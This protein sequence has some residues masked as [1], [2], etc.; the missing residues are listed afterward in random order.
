[1]ETKWEVQLI[2]IQYEI[3]YERSE[4]FDIK[5]GTVPSTFQWGRST[6]FLVLLE[7]V[8]IVMDGLKKRGLYYVCMQSILYNVHR[9]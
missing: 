2:Y 3:M 7:S 9:S 6:Y 5:S 4:L 1:M 8:L